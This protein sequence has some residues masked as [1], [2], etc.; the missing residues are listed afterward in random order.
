MKPLPNVREPYASMTR[1]QL[2][3][4]IDYMAKN[5]NQLERKLNAYKRKNALLEK[6]L[7]DPSICKH[8]IQSCIDCEKRCEVCGSDGD[9]EILAKDGCGLDKKRLCE[10]CLWDHKD[11]NFSCG[12]PLPPEETDE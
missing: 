8:G 11:G 4:H 2:V 5:Y 10:N 12:C 7:G 1:Q 9:M 6:R 3:D